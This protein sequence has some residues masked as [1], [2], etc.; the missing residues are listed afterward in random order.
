MQRLASPWN[1]WFELESKASSHVHF[2][3][4][5]GDIDFFGLIDDRYVYKTSGMNE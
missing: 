3:D 5:G 4:G 2:H 1:D